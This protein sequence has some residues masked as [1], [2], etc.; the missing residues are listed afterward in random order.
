MPSCKS[1]ITAF[2][3]F[4]YFCLLFIWLKKMLLMKKQVFMFFVIMIT[5][6][7]LAQVLFLYDTLS[8]QVLL[9]SSLASMLSTFIFWIIIRKRIQ[10]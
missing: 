5:F 1:L 2:S 4:N 9:Q 8:W 10:K 6:V 3:L 7:I